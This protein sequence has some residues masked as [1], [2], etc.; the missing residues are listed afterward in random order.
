MQ[1]NDII[2]GTGEKSTPNHTKSWVTTNSA[3]AILSTSATIPAITITTDINK[4]YSELEKKIQFRDILFDFD[5]YRGLFISNSFYEFSH[6]NWNSMLGV[7]LFFE[8]LYLF[9]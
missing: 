2:T 5:F 8:N 3:T 1:K 7:S 4:F 6:M 9:Q